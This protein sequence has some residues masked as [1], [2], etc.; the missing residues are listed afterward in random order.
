[1]THRLDWRFIPPV[2]VALVLRAPLL[3]VTVGASV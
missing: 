2:E 1:M 3:L